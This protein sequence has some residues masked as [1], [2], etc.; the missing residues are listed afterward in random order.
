MRAVFLVAWRE[1]R[2]YVFSRGFILFLVMMPLIL[3]FGAFSITLIEKARPIRAFVVYDQTGVY[4][5][6]IDAQIVKQ[7]SQQLLSAW[8]L[9]LETAVD[10]SKIAPSDIAFP[11]GSSSITNERREAFD[12]A[13]GFA[14][15]RAAAQ[16][17][18]RDVAPPFVEPRPR[19]QRLPLPEIAANAPSMD[20]A[21][22][23]LRP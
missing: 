20:E 17:Y 21:A 8:N 7:R 22:E 15:A 9:Y 12:E 23:A 3:L 18:L 1:Y 5:A 11:F 4:T 16:P 13:G 2:Q 19:F 6:L 10:R 14:A